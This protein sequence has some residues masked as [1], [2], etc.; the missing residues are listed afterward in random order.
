MLH[1]WPE[2]L[3]GIR[4]V[5]LT[6]LVLH[7]VFS[8]LVRV[9]SRKARPARYAVSKPLTSTISSRM[10]AITG[11][12]LLAF[13]IFH[14]AHYTAHTVDPS[15]ADMYDEKGRH[16][17]YRMV[18]D[19]FSKPLVSLFYI[20]SMVLLCSH[21]SH[22]AWSWLQTLGLRTKKTAV[23]TTH[24]GRILALVL[25]VGYIAVP[26]AVLAGFGKGYVAERRGLQ[27][28]KATVI[29]PTTQP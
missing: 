1:A 25:A 15:F 16:D 19:G 9:E 10:M 28:S 6:A 29:S 13:V 20:V 17:V 7:I 11:L 12:L 24:G 3:W 18:V 4:I 21:L 27:Q 22:G 14:L 26:V 2:A 23:G 5:L 8:I